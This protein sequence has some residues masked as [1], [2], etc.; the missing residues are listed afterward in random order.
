MI[1]QCGY[2]FRILGEDG[3]YHSIGLTEPVVQLRVAPPKTS[4]VPVSHGICSDCF[5]VMI[6]PADKEISGNGLLKEKAPQVEKTTP[7]TITATARG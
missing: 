4:E 7:S 6:A 5:Q 3:V 2:C 1:K